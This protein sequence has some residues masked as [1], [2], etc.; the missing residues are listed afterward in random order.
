MLSAVVFVFIGPVDFVGVFVDD[1]TGSFV[2]FVV[3]VPIA[4]FVVLSVVGLLVPLVGAVVGPVVIV[5]V[6]LVVAFCGDTLVQSTR[7]ATQLR[8]SLAILDTD[9]RS[10]GALYIGMYRDVDR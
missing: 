2:V 7:M 8:T 9:Y 3:G 5:A 4:S 1:L 6:V 10:G